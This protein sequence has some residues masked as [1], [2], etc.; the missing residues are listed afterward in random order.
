MHSTVFFALILA[1][2]VTAQP[3]IS[4]TVYNDENCRSGGTAQLTYYLT[5]DWQQCQALPAASG[6][7]LV[8]HARCE[9]NQLIVEYCGN[10]SCSAAT[11]FG[12]STTVAS[13]GC[14]SNLFLTTGSVKVQCPDNTHLKWID[15]RPYIVAW[16][17]AGFFLLTTI[18]FLVLFCKARDSNH[19]VRV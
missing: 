9:D 15:Q 1:A 3:G 13:S 7:F 18:I 16:V 10:K 12:P 4:V 17:G 2:V 14:S 19:H 5:D 11:C 8:G 6:Q